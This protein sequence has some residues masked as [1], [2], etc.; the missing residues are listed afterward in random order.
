[1]KRIMTRKKFLSFVSSHSER[2]INCAIYVSLLFSDIDE[3]TS[4]PMTA[5][6]L[7]YVRTVRGPLAVPVNLV[8]KEMGKSVKVVHAIIACIVCFY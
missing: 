7:R 4:K 1:M 2:K 5:T 6:E 8:T 3:C